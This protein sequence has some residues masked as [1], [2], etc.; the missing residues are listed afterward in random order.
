VNLVALAG[1][2]RLDQLPDVRLIVDDEN[3]GHGGSIPAGDRNA[4]Y[5]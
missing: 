4:G 1:Q 2:E 5:P 3:M